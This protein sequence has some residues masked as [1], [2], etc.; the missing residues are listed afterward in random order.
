MP[1]TCNLS[2]LPGHIEEYDGGRS[3]VIE[4]LGCELGREAVAVSTVAELRA[5][6]QDFGAR[7]QAVHP[8]ASFVVTISIRAEQRKP[9]GYDQAWLS[10]GFGQDNFLRVVNKRTA[11]VAEPLG[12]TATSGAPAASPTDG[13]LQTMAFEPVASWGSPTTPFQLDEQPPVGR[14]PADGR[15]WQCA[16]GHLG[17]YGWLCVANTHMLR[18]IG[19]GLMD[20]SDRVWRTH[21]E[22]RLHP[23]EVA[24]DAI[25][26]EA[27]DM[28]RDL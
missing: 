26:N 3:K 17:F 10:N 4:L 28:G 13:K 15:L 16:T 21:Y 20:L 7:L 9:N 14:G 27:T 12:A 25:A 1:A 18:R 11:A 8:D 6:V 2:A 24:D 23:C 19:I 22:D 5:G